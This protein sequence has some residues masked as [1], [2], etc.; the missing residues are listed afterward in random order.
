MPS[1]AVKPPAQAASEVAVAP[2]PK[3]VPKPHPL[4]PLGISIKAKADKSK[5]ECPTSEKPTNEAPECA[6]L[7]QEEMLCAWEEFAES[8]EDFSRQTLEMANPIVKG[9]S[10]IEVT[11]DNAFQQ[12]KIEEIQPELL[13][14]LRTELRNSSIILQ[15][16]LT[17]KEQS[18]SRVF[19][20]ED[21]LQD[22][23]KENT[24]LLNLMEALD[25]D[26]EI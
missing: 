15:I 4:P 18:D 14:F 8:K 12:N 20:A 1:Q 13:A 10:L 22:L 26:L 23:L 3:T 24:A 21:K 11:L 16:A 25:L 2:K 19:T 5:K 6:P 7:N 9:E 17:A